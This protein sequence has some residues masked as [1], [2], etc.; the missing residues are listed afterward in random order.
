MPDDTIYPYDTIVRIIEK[1]GSTTY[2][3]SG[4]LISPDEVLTASHVAY[5][6]GVGTATSI[7]VQPG[8]SPGSAPYGTISGTVTHFGNIGALGDLILLST[9]PND[10]ALIHLSA[11]VTTGYMSLGS[12]YSGGGVTVAGYPGSVTAAQVD[13]AQTVNTGSYNVL[14]GKSLGAGSSGGP[15][16]VTDV[17]GGATVVGIVSA[18]D[19]AGNG[20]FPKITQAIRTQL[21][22]WT[23]QDD[24]TLLTA[25]YVDAVTGASGRAALSSAVA[26]GPSYLDWQYIWSGIDNVSLATSVPNVFLKGGP[27]NDALAVVAGNNVLDGGSG[28]NFLVGGTGTDTF[29]TD[30]R[31]KAVVWNTIEN[32]HTGDS[33]TLWGFAAGV[34]NYVWESQPDGAP[35]STGATLRANIIGGSGRTGNGID[36]SIT[37]A[38]MSVAQAKALTVVTSSPGATPYLLIY[39]Q[40]V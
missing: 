8:Y 21:L 20:Y 10:Y 9:I 25:G 27:G 1:I 12:D 22:T 15:V 29:Y 16:F 32:F 24:G 40:G 17:L 4:V 11:P 34:S 14:V 5:M 28:S 33:A 39:D 37:F 35:G 31:P 18:S 13:Q 6:A 3:A 19:A 36:A 7:Q 26:G 38:G 30:A 2:E 23:A